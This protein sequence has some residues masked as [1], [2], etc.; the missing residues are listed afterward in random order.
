VCEGSATVPE[1]TRA[2]PAVVAAGISPR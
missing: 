2:D 1:T